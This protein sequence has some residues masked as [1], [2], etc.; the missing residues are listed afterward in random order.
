MSSLL[1]VVIV[2]SSWP[3]SAAASDECTGGDRSFV[4]VMPSL[5]SSVCLP[6]DDYI[7]LKSDASKVTH[8]ATENR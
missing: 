8:P 4:L 5:G 6:L 7:Q 3:G 2:S 1:L